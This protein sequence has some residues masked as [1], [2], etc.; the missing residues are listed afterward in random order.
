LIPCKR[1]VLSARH[2]RRGSSECPSADSRERPSGFW[3]PPQARPAPRLAAS[4]DGRLCLPPYPRLSWRSVAGATG[5]AGE[6]PR[7]SGLAAGPRG[8]LSRKRVSA[9]SLAAARKA[10]P[11]GATF[12][13]ASS[14]SAGPSSCRPAR[15]FTPDGLP[16]CYAARWRVEAP[17]RVDPSVC[18]DRRRRK[19]FASSNLAPSA[20]FST[21][22]EPG[23]VLQAREELHQVAQLGAGELLHQVRRHRGRAA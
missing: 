10:V 22:L 15:S 19:V 23:P 2:L 8:P 18:L 7:D 3:I 4:T 14:L 6:G 9:P 13:P 1:K 11:K 21:S 17:V 5:C 12:A 20:R 16:A